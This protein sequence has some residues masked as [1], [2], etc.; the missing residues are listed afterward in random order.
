M[1]R[2]KK[3]KE[4]KAAPQPPR[5]AL[6]PANL[7]N[8]KALYAALSNYEQQQNLPGRIEVL[9]KFIK[10]YQQLP[11]QEQM[12]FTREFL[13]LTALYAHLV[14]CM[15][16]LANKTKTSP[17]A[18][19]VIYLKLA[20]KDESDILSLKLFVSHIL[21][22]AT[23]EN[24]LKNFM[25]CIPYATRLLPKLLETNDTD[26]ISFIN[27]ITDQIMLFHRMLEEK[28]AP[29]IKN[30][31]KQ[32][33]PL[34]EEAYR[35]KLFRTTP[36]FL[37]FIFFLEEK[38]LYKEIGNFVLN[39]DNEQKLNPDGSLSKAKKKYLHTL[40]HS[41]LAF[42]YDTGLGDGSEADP[43]L[44]FRHYLDG[45][46]LG[47]MACMHNLALMYERGQDFDVAAPQATAIAAHRKALYWYERAIEQEH[48][49]S[50]INAL[51]LCLRH[52]G[53]CPDPTSLAQQAHNYFFITGSPSI[54]SSLGEAACQEKVLA[55]DNIMTARFWW[56]IGWLESN[57]PNCLSYFI[58]S[59]VFDAWPGS[60]LRTAAELIKK[61]PDNFP[62]LLKDKIIS[63]YLKVV[64]LQPAG[65]SHLFAPV[66][67]DGNELSST[68]KPLAELVKEKNQAENEFLTNLHASDEQMNIGTRKRKTLENLL[69]EAM[70]TQTP[71]TLANLIHK[72][73]QA[74]VKDANATLYLLQHHI[75]KLKN[76]FNFAKFF[77][78][79]CTPQQIVQIIQGL[80]CMGINPGQVDELAGCM[81]TYYQA[82]FTQLDAFSA[83]EFNTLI[84]GLGRVPLAGFYIDYYIKH[85]TISLLKRL[86]A[87]PTL[88]NADKKRYLLNTLYTYIV[89]EPHLNNPKIKPACQVLAKQ[90]VLMINQLPRSEI[91]NAHD[92]T[93]LKMIQRYFEKT[94][95][96]LRFDDDLIQEAEKIMCERLKA[97]PKT[98]H[99]PK[100]FDPDI[101]ETPEVKSGY[102]S[103][104]IFS[105]LEIAE[106]EQPPELACPSD[107]QQD[108]FEFI[109][110]YYPEARNEVMHPIVYLP[111]DIATGEGITIQVD[112]PSH[113]WHGAAGSTPVLNY[114]SRLNT[115]LIGDCVRVAYFE[116]RA[117]KD[118]D[119]RE[120]YL[121]KLFSDKDLVF[122]QKPQANPTLTAR[123]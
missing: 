94:H 115:D 43:Q 26:A 91:L 100:D 62:Q 19:Y 42:H 51:N 93:Q 5:L 52:P 97:S 87:A 66:S 72:L 122:P 76:I 33:F 20:I 23:D 90:M 70:P 12:I 110:R 7:E 81:H 75:Q 88:A 24:S 95:S 65:L 107:F 61:I 71:E 67:N 9:K 17:P 10:F 101:D 64:V 86:Q 112:G 114:K 120:N 29:I 39:K 27:V 60:S 37:T 38:R 14:S 56:M 6:Q 28:Y 8:F 78:Y 96:S 41:V 31:A 85:L 105:L 98:A 109:Q 25:K 77:V 58:Q 92:A 123:K 1:P 116:W 108:V 79:D 40:A 32:L 68:R 18:E 48:V 4:K 104:N 11:A 46:Q 111:V 54:F 55:Y 118:D 119:A 99:A 36:A 74:L 21:K 16:E 44:A 13:S 69:R 57:Y 103:P 121:N 30:L 83:E 47:A 84:L 117:L 34:L 80:T 45:A 73:G 22:A 59:Y 50:C 2:P 82:V 102:A 49:P 53:I 3:P 113:F 63:S 15:N 89:L 106:P 35:K